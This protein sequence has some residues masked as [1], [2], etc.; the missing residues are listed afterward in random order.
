[1][2]SF[3]TASQL[4]MTETLD[5]SANHSCRYRMVQRRDRLSSALGN[6]KGRL[7]LCRPED[8]GWRW[9]FHVTLVTK[10]NED[11]LSQHSG[12]LLDVYREIACERSPTPF[13][14][15]QRLECRT[16]VRRDQTD[17]LQTP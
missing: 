4:D 16:A 14:I 1:M 17:T 8:E 6:S 15:T 5:S 3:T 12:A 7:D 2:V 9:R 11:P 10:E 13:R